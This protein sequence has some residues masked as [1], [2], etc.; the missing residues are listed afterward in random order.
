[1][2]RLET[3]TVVDVETLIKKANADRERAVKRLI[4]AWGSVD[5]KK[6]NAI[7][8]EFRDWFNRWKI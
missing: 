4:G 6:I 1:M 7:R 2:E 8:K 3:A 5:N